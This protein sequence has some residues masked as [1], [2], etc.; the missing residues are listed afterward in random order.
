MNQRFS[1]YE[2]TNMERIL[3]P[4]GPLILKQ[5]WISLTLAFKLCE[6]KSARTNQEITKIDPISMN[7]GEKI[8]NCLLSGDESKRQCCKE[9]YCIGTWNVRSMSQ[10]K[11]DMVK[12]EMARL[13]T[14]ISG[15]SELKWM[16]MG[17]FNSDDHRWGKKRSKRQGEKGKIYSECRVLENSKE[18]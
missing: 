4:Q 1:F 13:N 10:G 11:L 8:A 14:D 17:G 18:R 12:Q 5:T 3:L 15:I 6:T 9:K 2:H 7:G 16:G